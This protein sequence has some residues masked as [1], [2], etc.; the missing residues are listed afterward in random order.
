MAGD[1]R[2]APD[3]VAPIVLVLGGFLTSPPLYVPM[4]RRLLERGAAG[5]VVAS[6]WTPDWL[7]AARRGVG[8]IVTR[9]GRALLAAGEMAA[10]SPR[11]LGAPLLVVGHSAGGITARLLTSPESFAGRRLGAAGRIGAIVT[12]GTPHRVTQAGWAGRRL[13][14][15]ATEFANRVVPGP[16]FA[17]TTG[18]LAVASRYRVGRRHGDRSERSAF[19]VYRS[20]LAEAADAANAADAADAANAP[21]IDAPA[22]IDAD[23]TI[24]GDGLVP[25]PSAA[26]AG[27]E[28]IV[29]EGIA[30]GQARR[31]PWYG[32]DEALDVWWPRAVAVW[33]AAL[34]ARLGDPRPI[35]ARSEALSEL[36]S[37]DDGGP[38]RV[39][40]EVA[41][42]SS[43][44]SS[45]S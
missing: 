39:S 17:P 41:G 16:A 42:W 7:L 43:G 36:D 9:S 26:L 40:S 28:A 34:Q 20:V 12:L 29:L 38:S 1:W 35:V 13:A 3:K 18:Y 4:R 11:S 25:V 45:G 15:A 2:D 32:S 8:P 44:S 31:A 27:V 6:V 23:A 30:H 33:Q 19:A 21:G 24:D 37:I 14:D 22:G 5:V 10:R